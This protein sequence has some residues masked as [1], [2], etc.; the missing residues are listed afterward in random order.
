[1]AT[2][3]AE[4]FKY[5]ADIMYLDAENRTERNDYTMELLRRELPE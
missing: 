1:M 2:D 4:K 3:W 5:L